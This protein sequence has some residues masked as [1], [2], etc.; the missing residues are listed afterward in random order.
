MTPLTVL[1]LLLAL[2]LG[3][4]AGI[5]IGS[6]VLRRDRATVADHTAATVA[7][8]DRVVA[9]V[10][11]SLVRFETRL[12]E[13]EHGTVAAQ[14]AL[15]GQLETVRR[16][17]E[18][19]RREAARLT[20]ALRKP[21]ARGRWGELH[22]QR[23]VELAGMTARVDFDTQTTVTD[24]DGR[25]RPDMVVHLPGGKH[26]VVDS[27]V[28]LAAFLEAGDTD[29]QDEQAALM[30]SHARH[31]RNHV[32]G[33]ASKRYW[34]RV[35]AT[36]EFV[37]MFLP[38]ESF[39]S[40]ALDADPSLLEYAFAQKIV[41]ATP[42]TLVALL[43]TVAI[44]WSEAALAENAREVFDIAREMY[45]RLG[46]FAGHLSKVGRSLDTSV[47]AYNAAVGSMEE[48]FLVS[49]RKLVSLDLADAAIPAPS[50]VIATSRR[51]SA[52]ELLEVADPP[53]DLE[54]DGPRQG[55]RD[56]HEDDRAIS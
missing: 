31:V 5:L 15:T 36:P 2:A 42:T 51:L 13:L 28:P 38:G 21:Q 20:N 14:A 7:A 9:P 10:G 16:S 29:D 45:S 47:M 49:A 4:A 24:A 55:R 41:P 52:H 44:S 18:E 12:R 19:L 17:G 43:R 11:E 26:V 23:T 3:L 6:G 40:A 30:A 50:P 33:L 34:A 54:F 1:L 46:V 56:A 8:T 53:P 27:K 48:R 37:V 35:S 22:L 32:D 25:H 39:L